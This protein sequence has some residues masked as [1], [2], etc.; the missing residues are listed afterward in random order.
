MFLPI[1]GGNELQ[2]RIYG[3]LLVAKHFKV[4]LEILATIANIDQDTNLF[5]TKHMSEELDNIIKKKYYEQSS[6]FNDILG[7]IAKELG[8]LISEKPVEDTPSVHLTFKH[9]DRSK[10]VAYE[11]KF[12]DLVIAASPPNGVVTATFEAAIN[13]SGKSALVIPRV[14]KKFDTKSCIIGWNGS[15]EISR[16]ITSSMP[17]LKS[18]EN[19]LIISSKEYINDIKKLDKL[20]E[21]LLIHGINSDVKLV[22]TTKIPGQALLDNALEGNFDLIIASAHGYRGLREMFFGGATKYLLQNSTLPVFISQ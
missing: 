18:A 8:V 22:K 21:Y 10:L 19:V 7:K 16:A 20:K 13:D 14:M 17:I 15:T 3:A 11:S 12:C 6:K 2:E 5:L 1:G 4:H 9:G